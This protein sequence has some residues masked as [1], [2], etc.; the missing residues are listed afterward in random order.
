MKKTK[1]NIKNKKKKIENKTIK[2]SI[3]ISFNTRVILYCLLFLTLFVGGLLLLINSFDFTKEKSI[4][5]IEKSNLNYK[6]YLKNNEFYDTPY[7]DK[8][9]L[10]IASL[11]DKVNIDFNYNFTSDEKLN[12]D[13]NYKIIGKLTIM[14]A[15]EKNLYFEKE[16]ILLDN[17]ITNMVEDNFHTIH[18][19]VDIDYGYYN[20]LANKFKMSY[21]IDAT[22]KLTIYLV[23]DKN[24]TDNEEII[25]NNLSQMSLIVPLSE[26][27]INI[28]LDYNEIN[29]TNKLISKSNVI[30]DNIIYMIVSLILIIISIV[31]IIKFIRLVILLKNTKNKYDK[32]IKK[33]LTEYDRLIV[34]TSTCPIITGDNVIKIR[35]FQELLDVRD[36]LKLPIMYYSVTK[37]QKCYF[38]ITYENKIYLNIVKAVDLEENNKQ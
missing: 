23:I 32:Y 3:Y 35:K 6:V 15:G 29:N 8:N 37:H 4:N 36:N 2:N 27:A 7:L 1:K 30:I 22:S 26:K 13:F 21:G 20:N 28:K 34:E 33:L 17:K 9:M 31:I 38:Y 16:Y 10:Y 24:S 14:D 19:S 25:I 12:L 11:I 18:E 5:Y